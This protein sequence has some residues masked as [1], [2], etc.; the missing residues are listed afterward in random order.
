[1]KLLL[2]LALLAVTAM[3]ARADEYP[4]PYLV[5]TTSSGEQTAVAVDELVI[6]FSDGKLVAQNAAGTQ[7]FTLTDL[8]S[9]NFSATNVLT[10]G[11]ETISSDQLA[12]GAAIYDLSGRK[13]QISQ[14]SNGQLPR[15]VYIVKQNGKTSKMYVK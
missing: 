8:A 7:S 9:M 10:D 4:Y 15:G 5:M 1:M 2:T 3:V 12:E 11:V 13:L 6:T 14:L